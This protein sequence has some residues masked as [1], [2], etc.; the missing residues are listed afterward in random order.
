MNNFSCEEKNYK[1]F[2]NCLFVSGASVSILA[3]LD[4]GIRIFSF[5]KTG[6]VN[7]FYEQEKD[8][9]LFS[10]KE[11]WRIYGGH[12]LAFAPESEKTY[13]PDNAPVCYTVLE[14]GVRLEQEKDSYLNCAKTMELSFTGNDCELQVVHRISNAGKE[15]MYG[16]PWAITAMA[17]GGT[18]SLPWNYPN[19]FTATPDRFVSLWNSTQLRDPRINFLKDSVKIQQLLLD[20]YFKIGFFGSEG[21]I[22]YKNNGGEFQITSKPEK[23]KAYPDN[24]VN[25]EIFA[26]KYMMELET[27]APLCSLKPGDSC[28]HRELWSIK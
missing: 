2:G 15:A 21:I 12:R 7:L 25:I 18:M 22:N 4:F 6:G 20:D 23:G 16:A 13:W 24:N 8:S 3:S 19:D 10:T 28:E 1:H 9:N 14:N 17:A 26:C 27:L 11:G 5:S